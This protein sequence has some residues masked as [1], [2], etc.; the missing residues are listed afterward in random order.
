MG[1]KEAED[2][3]GEELY[4]RFFEGDKGAFDELVEL[5]EHELAA[6]INGFVHDYHEAKHLMIETFAQLVVSGGKFAGK[7]SLKTYIFTIGKNLA[8]RYRKM[9]AHFAEQHI[10]YEDA[11]EA[12]VDENDAPENF[13]EREENKRHLH[14]A[15]KDLKAEYREVLEFL[16][17]ED[18]S[19]AEAGRIMKKSEKQISNLA[20]RAK[21]AL[22]KKLENAKFTY[23]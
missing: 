13:M 12:L 4:S 6:F 14:E 19:Y 18:M 17:F 21:A 23:V 9:R 3:T 16:Y 5:Y 11:I 1:Y 7:S 20:Y 15:I 10:S 2:I 8:L 22:K